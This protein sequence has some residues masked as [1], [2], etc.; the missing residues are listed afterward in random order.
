MM[1]GPEIPA[2]SEKRKAVG[3]LDSLK[4]II[5]RTIGTR[6]GRHAQTARKTFCID[7][8]TQFLNH[9][10]RRPDKNKRLFS[11]HHPARKPEILG[12]KPY[13]G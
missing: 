10:P 7:L 9:P 3:K 4:F 6:Y 1:A 5:N 13:P 2:P 11:L 12:K 8:V